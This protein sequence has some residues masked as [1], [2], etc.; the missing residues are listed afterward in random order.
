MFRQTQHTQNT[1][2]YILVF[3]V[4]FTGPA[5]PHLPGL[6]RCA[7]HVF[8]RRRFKDRTLQRQTL[9]DCVEVYPRTADS[10]VEESTLLTPQPANEHDITRVT[11][12][13][14]SHPL[15]PERLIYCIIPFPVLQLASFEEVS[16][17]KVYTTCISGLP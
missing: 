13:S 4:H 16:L 1:N 8:R 5:L 2:N 12:N 7:I 14:Y 17:S 9:Y 6:V 11:F 15:I 10:R 3:S